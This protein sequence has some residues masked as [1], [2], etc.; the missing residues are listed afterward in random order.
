VQKGSPCE[1][2]EHVDLASRRG[3]RHGCGRGG[4]RRPVARV[5]AGG[6]EGPGDRRHPRRLAVEAPQGV[7]LHLYA[8]VPAHLHTKVAGR[9]S[10]RRC[11]SESLTSV[12]I[13]GKNT[14]FP[15]KEIPTE[16]RTTPSPSQIPPESLPKHC[17][18]TAEARSARARSARRAKHL[19]RKL[20]K[21]GFEPRTPGRRPGAKPAKQPCRAFLAWQLEHTYTQAT[22]AH[23][24]GSNPR[25]CDFGRTEIGESDA[26]IFL[27]RC[28][29]G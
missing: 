1:R 4:G 11:T 21:T 18:S 3:R 15:E 20:P 12:H 24:V 22:P 19:A 9:E 2:I 8:H 27:T 13:V 6:P 28:T 14:S 25:G 29:V 23:G 26:H 7:H 16:K 10:L 17:R 5:D